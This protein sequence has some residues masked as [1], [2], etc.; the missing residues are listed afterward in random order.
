[1][2]ENIDKR[3]HKILKNNV[4]GMVLGVAFILLTLT[5]MKSP[6]PCTFYKVTGYYCP[7]CGGTRALTSLLKGEIRQSFRYNS[8]IYINTIVVT[9]VEVFKVNRKNKEVVYTI[10]VVIS[11]IYGVLRN[12]DEFRYLAPTVIG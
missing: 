1:M 9:C 3:I 12:L 6:I 8:L 5:L 11:I 2:L 10:L 7:G 4:L